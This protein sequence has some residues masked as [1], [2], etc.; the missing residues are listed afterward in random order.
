M[1][2]TLSLGFCL[3]DIHLSICASRISELTTFPNC[4]SVKFDNSFVI[5]YKSF[6]YQ[7]GDNT[8]LQIW[9]LTLPFTILDWWDP[10]RSF[11]RTETEQSAVPFQA[12]FFL[13]YLV[14]VEYRSGEVA[15]LF[16]E[17]PFDLDGKQEA[18]WFEEPCKG[19]VEKLTR[20]G[21][22]RPRSSYFRM[23]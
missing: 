10:M 22:W 12:H 19:E 18:W 7:F 14:A 4:F 16:L 1:K 20:K 5:W 3:F 8:F 15:S 9:C 11:Q 13:T 2:I 23:F 21:L 6:E 17:L